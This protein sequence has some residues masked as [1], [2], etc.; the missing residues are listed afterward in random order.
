MAGAVGDGVEFEPV[1]TGFEPVEF[2][3]P[4]QYPGDGATDLVGADHFVVV[5]V[6]EFEKTAVGAVGVDVDAGQR[7]LRLVEIEQRAQI[8][9]AADVQLIGS[10]DPSETHSRRIPV[11]LLHGSLPSAMFDVSKIIY[12][13][14]GKKT[15]GSPSFSEKNG[16]FS[17]FDAFFPGPGV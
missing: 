8:G 4:L 2:P 10:T 7:P 16:I 15:A 12:D 1:G 9:F 3:Q 11:R 14:G 5:V 6:D 17:G 13:C